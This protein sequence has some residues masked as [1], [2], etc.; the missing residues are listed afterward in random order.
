M[1]R[2]QTPFQGSG[3]RLYR[4]VI[5]KTQ[6]SVKGHRII[7]FPWMIM[8]LRVGNHN[9]LQEGYTDG[10]SDFSRYMFTIRDQFV[11]APYQWETTLQCNVVSHWL[12]T[13]TKWSLIM[14][15]HNWFRSWRELCTSRQSTWQR[16]DKE[17]INSTTVFTLVILLSSKFWL[18]D[19][20]QIL[21]IAHQICCNG[22][23]NNSYHCQEGNYSK[24]CLWSNLNPELVKTIRIHY[25]L[26]MLMW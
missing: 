14:S 15:S 17:P 9:V 25:S 23:H 24:I 21:H 11:Y 18:N 8:L 7:I 20:H 13:Y 10:N 4:I 26:V 2:P 12:G 19:H 1:Q 22:L 5:N 6:S 16:N 3:A